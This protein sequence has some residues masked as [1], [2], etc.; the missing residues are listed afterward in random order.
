[1]IKPD[2]VVNVEKD[3]ALVAKHLEE[4][5]AIFYAES[6]KLEAQ[7]ADLQEKINQLSS[8]LQ[9]SNQRLGILLNAIPAGV[10]LLENN[11]VLLH[12]PAVL[13]FLP[14]L[15][16]GNQFALPSEWQA[17]IA[18]GE[19]VI[20]NPEDRNAPQKMVQVIQINEGMR[21]FI[22]IQDI[23]A[24]IALHQETQRENRL[25]AMG[26]MAAGI[27]HQFRTPLATA[28]LYSSHL[29]DDEVEPAMAKEFALRLR[30]QLLDLEKL[31]QD[32][33][34]FISNRP[35]KTVLT[36]AQQLIEEAQASIQAL[37]ETKGVA[38]SIQCAIPDTVM[39][40]V[41]PK[42]IPN[43]LVAILENALAVSKADDTVVLTVSTESK[44]LIVTIADQGPGIAS[45]MID[46]LFE[47]FSTTSA[48]GTGLGLSIAKNTLD[49][50]RGTIG[51]YNTQMGAVFKITLP[52]TQS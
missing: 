19:Y 16:K 42:S 5:F 51:A 17:S 28:L 29:C 40:L 15:S 25:T 41:E 2:S 10:I 35:N 21:S 30:K 1:L 45:T 23:T 36:S 7:Q 31:S 12:N 26:K 4:A 27:A 32:M 8:E 49:A 50:H 9:Q 47:P 33:L 52:I 18:P 44:K 22:Q 39:L 13:Q 11:I 20:G 38:L 6:Q 48:N 34:R 46:S 3:P 43:A 24:N 37:F 14:S